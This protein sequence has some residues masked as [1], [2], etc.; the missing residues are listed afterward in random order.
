[1][2]KNKKRTRTITVGENY[3]LPFIRFG[4]AYLINEL[5]FSAGDTLEI[6]RDN[7]A[8][9]LRKLDHHEVTTQ[10][11]SRLTTTFKRLFNLCERHIETYGDCRP[12]NRMAHSQFFNYLKECHQ[13]ISA[14]SSLMDTE[15]TKMINRYKKQLVHCE[16]AFRGYPETALIHSNLEEC[17]TLIG[18]LMECGQALGIFT[19]RNLFSFKNKRQVFQKNNEKFYYPHG[20]NPMMVAE[21][22]GANYDITE[23][24]TRPVYNTI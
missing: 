6:V 20:L 18:L 19:R 23:E 17:Q 24:M 16:R 15:I 7:G 21:N 13:V 14:L 4:G 8:V 9:I 3:D 1:M 22:R 2:A 12:M 5:G 10:N 11:I